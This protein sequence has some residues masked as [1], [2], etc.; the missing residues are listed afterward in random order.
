VFRDA[1]RAWNGGYPATALEILDRAG[2][3]EFERDFMEAMMRHNR[4]HLV[5]E[6]RATRTRS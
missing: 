1:A 3:G 4:D 6:I 2:Y 5:R